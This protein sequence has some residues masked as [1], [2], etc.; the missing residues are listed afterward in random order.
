MILKEIHV[1]NFKCLKD[2]TVADLGNL[3]V[4]IGKNNSGKSTILEA[5][6]RSRAMHA[7]VDLRTVAYDKNPRNQVRI[8][9]TFR[10][11][12]ETR[13]DLLADQLNQLD[14]ERKYATID[15]DFFRN[16]VFHIRFLPTSGNNALT[17]LEKVEINDLDGKMI[18]I[19]HMLDARTCEI[20]D[21]RNSIPSL[22][23]KTMSW[24]PKWRGEKY[25]NVFDAYQS[26]PQIDLLSRFMY[27][28]VEV[29]VTE[30]HAGWR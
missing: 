8:R 7:K 29:W 23:L 25:P 6:R 20:A 13:D 16:V 18:E 4:F 22:R 12:K 28:V 30:T 5:L 27:E 11:K 9:L 19:F 21:L 17:S 1:E 15:S 14:E 26:F 2:V 10:L 24:N 3:S